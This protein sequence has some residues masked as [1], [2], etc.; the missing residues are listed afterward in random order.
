MAT[1]TRFRALLLRVLFCALA[2]SHLGES[3]LF[4]IGICI[5]EDESLRGKADEQDACL[6]SS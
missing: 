2:L 6:W 3:D 5:A 1:V 4:G